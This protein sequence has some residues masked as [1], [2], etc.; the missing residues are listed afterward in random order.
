VRTIAEWS[1]TL[2]EERTDSRSS[3]GRWWSVSFGAGF[4]GDV[5]VVVVSVSAGSAFGAASTLLENRR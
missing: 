5:A 4:G 3:V 2:S 1:L